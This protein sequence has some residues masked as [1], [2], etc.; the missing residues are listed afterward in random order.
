MWW[1]LRTSFDITNGTAIGRIDDLGS[2]LGRRCDDLSN[3]AE[4][5][6]KMQLNESV[7]RAIDIIMLVASADQPLTLTEICKKTSIPKSSAFS[8]L[9]TLVRKSVLEIVDENAKTFRLGL[10]LFET[11][12]AALSS[13]D[14]LKAA[15]P[16]LDGLNR[17]TGE[18][19]LFAVED[20]GEMVF[21]DVLEGTGHLRPL[22]K[23]GGR[24]HM[25]CTAIGKAVLAA[26]PEAKLLEFLNTAQLSSNTKQTITSRAELMKELATTR[27]RGYSIDNEENIDDI[28]CI[29][30][31][32]YSRTHKVIAGMSITMQA[33]RADADKLNYYGM[34]I[35]NTALKVSRRMGFGE[36]DLYWDRDHF[37]V[38]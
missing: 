24:V 15:R 23:L 4:C 2:A 22:V 8:I 28:A 20:E 3:R 29:G 16:F 25:H 27:Q 36:A 31:P 1:G 21:L 26:L 30:A 18:T 13:T 34:V 11:T 37:S 12:L 7:S 32:I 5:R 6:S 38:L 35:H 19:V 10:G 33:S 17:L 14:L 9:H